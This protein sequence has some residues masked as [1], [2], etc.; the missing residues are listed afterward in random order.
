MD[1]FYPFASSL[2]EVIEDR[3]H[4]TSKIDFTNETAKIIHANNLSEL[5]IDGSE[6][7][8][9]YLCNFLKIHFL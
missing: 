5:Q 4:T 1:T 9:E 3:L 7:S 6:H 8:S 2:Q